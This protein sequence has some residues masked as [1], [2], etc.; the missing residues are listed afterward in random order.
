[1]KCQASLKKLNV[2]K[3]PKNKILSVNLHPVLISLLDFFTYEAGT[4][5][6]PCNIGA[7]LPL[8]TV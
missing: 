4:N 5:W 8:C 6:L 7:E 2:D 3:I 1:L